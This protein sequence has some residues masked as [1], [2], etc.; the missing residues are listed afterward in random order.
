MYSYVY[1]LWIWSYVIHMYFWRVFLL[2]S[3]TFLF[4][5]FE[6]STYYRACQYCYF[7][8]ISRF[9]EQRC[10]M[11][12]RGERLQKRKVEVK[13][14]DSQEWWRSR[15]SEI[16][17]QWWTQR[18]MRRRKNRG[19][20]CRKIKLTQD[21]G[22]QVES[23]YSSTNTKNQIPNYGIQFPKELPAKIW[24]RIKGRHLL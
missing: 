21:I 16:K 13:T 1:K 11:K 23:V 2:R 4:L 3:R 20:W 12:E 8:A 19:A 17:R 24:Q 5:A 6:T 9:L 15:G 7:G 22:H 18:M 10:Q 14:K